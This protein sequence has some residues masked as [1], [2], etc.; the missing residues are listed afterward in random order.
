MREEFFQD[1]EVPP[2]SSKPY[3]MDFTY[4]YD[5]K[6]PDFEEFSRGK[7]FSVEEV[8]ADVGRP[9]DWTHR[10]SPPSQ[11]RS[12]EQAAQVAEQLLTCRRWQTQPWFTVDTDEEP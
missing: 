4:L 9:E 12:E 2:T 11:A 6:Q 8:Y 1:R 7:P 5:E 10:A 3:L